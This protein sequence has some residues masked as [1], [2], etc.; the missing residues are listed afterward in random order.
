MASGALVDDATIGEV[1][2]DRLERPDA[3]AGFLL[4]GYPR[5]LPQ[6]ESLAA[7]LG[8]SSRPLDL[9]LL[10]DV[11][12]DE[13]VR[14]AVARGREDDKEDVVRERLR[15]YREKTEP[16]IGYYRRRGLLRVVDGDRPIA[17]VTAR[18][19]GLCGVCGVAG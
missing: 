19:L 18:L 5:T 17:E 16:L 8:R 15:V 13:L 1:V 4:D 6:A 3:R 12:E 2:R 9:V 14:R 11:A 7:M 10:V